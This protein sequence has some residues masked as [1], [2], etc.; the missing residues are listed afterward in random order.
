MPKNYKKIDD[1]INLSKLIQ[2]INHENESKKSVNSK[3]NKSFFNR[4]NLNQK[5]LE[6]YSISN[7]NNTIENNRI[8][9]NLTKKLRNFNLENNLNV[10]NIKE[11]L[12]NKHLLKNSRNLIKI[13]NNG[14]IKNNQKDFLPILTENNR[15]IRPNI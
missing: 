1:K 7:R 2:N 5:T 6:S 10:K 13:K 9:L 3:K 8:P 11:D 15:N 4:Y 12:L 14:I